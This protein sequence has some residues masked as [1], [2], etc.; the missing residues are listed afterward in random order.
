MS[1]PDKLPGESHPSAPARI[2]RETIS[3]LDAKAELGLST[4]LATARLAQTGPNEVPERRDHPLGSHRG[5]VLGP[6]RVDARA[7]NSSIL[8]PEKNAG[9]MGGAFASFGE[10]SAELRSRAARLD[11]GGRAARAAPDHARTCHH[12]GSAAKFRF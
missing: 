8:H 3:S 5:E 9:P 11:D 6:F 1:A 7:H 12:P 4:A 2:D 10:C